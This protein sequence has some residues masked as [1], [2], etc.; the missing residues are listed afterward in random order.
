[1]IKVPNY[2]QVELF[3][4]KDNDQLI[5]V[6]PPHKWLE[7]Q[8]SLSII[9]E[10]GQQYLFQ[11]KKFTHEQHTTHLTLSSEQL[12]AQR[13]LKQEYIS[14]GKVALPSQP[15]IFTLFPNN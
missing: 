7:E 1:M 2:L 4:K 6:C 12:D 10:N 14:I 11:I 5:A 15:L 8:E 9:L 3:A 13:F